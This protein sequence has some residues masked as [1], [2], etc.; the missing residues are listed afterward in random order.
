MKIYFYLFQTPVCLYPNSNLDKG[1]FKNE[2]IY[3]LELEDCT[4]YW[5]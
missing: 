1:K 3:N 5:N 2:N 4:N